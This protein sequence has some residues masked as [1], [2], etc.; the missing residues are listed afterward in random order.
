MFSIGEFASEALKL[1]KLEALGVLH[2]LIFYEVEGL[3]V[4]LF[5]YLI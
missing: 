3:K 5:G 1:V 4:F 2:G